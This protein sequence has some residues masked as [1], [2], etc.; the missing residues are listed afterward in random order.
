[1]RIGRI[2]KA[3][4]QHLV[5][6]LDSF[7]NLM[8]SVTQKGEIRMPRVFVIQE[9]MKHNLLPAQAF[10]DL[11]FLL[12]PQVQITFSPGPI[13]VRMER[14]LQGFTEDDYLLLIGDPAAMA[15]AGALVAKHNNGRFK[16]LKWDKREMKYYPIQVDTNKGERDEY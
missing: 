1:M 9:T 5:S 12:P 13:V 7:F 4:V 10:G 14:H 6:F 15:V 11:V 3:I 16:L 8:Y 2:F